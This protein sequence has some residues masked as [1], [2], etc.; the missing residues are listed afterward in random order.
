MN[1]LNDVTVRLIASAKSWIEGEAIRQLYAVAK[2][3]G[4]R[5]AIGF[6]DLHPGEGTPGGAAFVTENLV[7][8]YVVGSDIGC[9]MGLWKTDL[10][11]RKVKLDRWEEVRFDLEV[12]WHGDVRERLAQEGLESTAFDAA[13]GTIG[14]GN[15]FA[16][17]QAVEKIMNHAEFERLALSE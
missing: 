3:E 8:P 17:A 10:A 2:L 11:R 1:T 6:P 13:F 4:M 9:G 15:H 7:H 5:L 16:E 12:P 14:G